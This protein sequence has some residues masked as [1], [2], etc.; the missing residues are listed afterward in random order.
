MKLILTITLLTTF[1]NSFAQSTG[2]KKATV[3]GSF[4]GLLDVKAVKP[5]AGVYFGVSPIRP[6][7]FGLGFQ[8]LQLPGLA[9]KTSKMGIDLFGEFRL[10]ARMKNFTPSLAFQYGTFGYNDAT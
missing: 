2:T 9:A 4:Y 5:G 3:Y 10:F 7:G 8:M 1:L 6:A